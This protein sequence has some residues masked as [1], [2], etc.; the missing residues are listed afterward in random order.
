M[1]FP[2]V[3]HF[4]PIFSLVCLIA[5]AVIAV[6]ADEANATPPRPTIAAERLQPGEKIVL[7]GRLDEPVWQ[8]AKPVGGFLQRDP[9]EGAPATQATEVRVAYDA[10]T[11]YIGAY[12]HDTEPD[13]ILS[14]LR[15][16]DS[17]LFSDDMFA[18]ALDPFADGRTVY[19][20]EINPDGLMHDGL[21]NNGDMPN[22]SWDGIWDVRTARVADGWQAEFA[23][24][25]RT[26]NF[27][28]ARLDWAINFSRNVRRLNESSL[29]AAHLRSQ[30]Q[31][32]TLYAGRLTGLTGITQG[33]GLEFRPY[34]TGRWR[35]VAGQ[36]GQFEKDAGF[37]LTYSLTAN[38]RAALTIN[39][40]FADTEVDERQVNLGV[41]PLVFPEKRSF[42]LESSSV[43]SFPVDDS[44]TPFY[45]RRI[46]L[47]EDGPVPLAAGGRLAGQFHNTDIGVLQL[48]TKAAFGRAG[49]DFTALRAKTSVGA[50]NY[51]GLLYTRRA[52]TMV[53]AGETFAA[54]ARF[55]LAEIRPG[56]KVTLTTYAIDTSRAATDR[57]SDWLDRSVLGTVVDWNGDPLWIYTEFQQTGQAYDP[58]V[59]FAFDTGYRKYHV[60]TDYTFRPADSLVRKTEHRVEFDRRTDLNGRLR[61][62]AVE[63]DLAHVEFNSGDTIDV[64]ARLPSERFT[65]D[66]GIW[67]GVV[68]PAGRYDG[69]EFYAHVDTTQM[70]WWMAQAG[71]QR[72]EFYAGYRTGYD[73]TLRVRPAA[74]FELSLH[75]EQQEVDLPGGR[76]ITRLWRGRADYDFTT[77]HSL[78]VLGQ[79]DNAS[80]TVGLQVRFRWIVRPGS[81]LF[82]GY[83]HDWVEL[84]DPLAG[85]QRWHTLDR[86]AAIKG[87]YTWR[88]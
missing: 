87:F 47:S 25:F 88:F 66:F 15:K 28:P 40:D 81:E 82:V 10:D 12:L 5:L 69:T 53:D 73:A 58:A 78:N 44:I 27:D 65:E 67:P 42:F 39:T 52:G 19:F 20:F 79:F 30:G 9:Q 59:G 8:R 23:I 35:Q 75:G 45:S 77:R 4:R 16:R 21:L 60:A 86:E 18:I 55:R 7:D 84:N 70:R 31:W 43:F 32:K 68:V 38:L 51:V 71:F 76:F 17:M 54:D 62:G 2:F 85:R 46:G 3:P 37:D 56:E 63:F 61:D 50:D 48:R 64:S 29:W 36:S 33:R 74:G 11:L 22:F 57:T 72:G 6:R 1:R 26:L 14:Y 49:E 13:K 41:Y 83:L 34:V 80:D 24:P